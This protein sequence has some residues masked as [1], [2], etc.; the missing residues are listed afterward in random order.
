MRL[1]REE[2]GRFCRSEAAEQLELSFDVED[3]KKLGADDGQ[4]PVF[5][6]D[7]FCDGRSQN[8]QQL[9]RRTDRGW[10]EASL[11]RL[12]REWE[13]GVVFSFDDEGSEVLRGSGKTLSSKPCRSILQ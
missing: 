2:I 5:F 3:E 4:R 10:R 8:D 7:Q 12:R 11:R 9:T 6:C 1:G 13:V